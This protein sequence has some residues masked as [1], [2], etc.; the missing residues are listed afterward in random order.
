MGRIEA[1]EVSVVTIS[2]R[3]RFPHRQYHATPWDQAANNGIV[4]WPPAPWRLH[5][6]LIAVAHE[7]YPSVPPE[8]VWNALGP[9]REPPT[10]WLPESRSGHTRHYLPKS[11]QRSGEQSTQLTLASYVTVDPRAELVIGWPDANLTDDQRVLLDD[12]VQS[13]PY[14]GRAESVVEAT[15]SEALPEDRGFASVWRPH[16]HGLQR[17]LSPTLDVT[18]AQLEM[19]P[20]QMR[21]GRRLTP[22]GSQWVGYEETVQA[23]DQSPPATTGKPVEVIRWRVSSPAPFM[24]INGILATDRLRMLAVSLTKPLAE[25]ED[26][27]DDETVRLPRIV[28]RDAELLA[29][30]RSDASEQQHEHAHWLWTEGPDGRIEYVILWVPPKIS[31]ETAAELVSYFAWSGLTARKDGYTPAGFVDSRL[32]LVGWGDRTVMA[33]VLPAQGGEAPGARVWESATPHLLVRRGKRNQSYASLAQED[34]DKELAFRFGDKAPKATVEVIGDP[35]TA[36]R[37]RRLRWKENLT[38]RKGRASAPMRPPVRIRVTFDR[39]WMDPLVLGGLSH[40][41]FGRLEPVRE[42]SVR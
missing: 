10:Y 19:T 2:I 8:V 35:R 7:R 14:L 34:V 32:H 15:L 22:E 28:G 25:R 36:L 42:P 24:G 13:L 4:E 21:K 17:L 31:W 27:A 18:R 40:F 26:G 39:E 20:D 38:Q 30:H 3:I 6:A 33:D 9:L 16:P 12:L 23:V 29:G 11:S 1:E 37:Y 41:G 5:R